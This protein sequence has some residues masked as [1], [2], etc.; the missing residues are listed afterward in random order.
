MS[1]TRLEPPPR[2]ETAVRTVAQALPDAPCPD[3]IIPEPHTISEDAIVRL[4]IGPNGLTRETVVAYAPVTISARF[5]DPDQ[6]REFLRLDF[7]RAGDWHHQIVE[8]SVALDPQKLLGLAVTGFPV[9]GKTAKSLAVYLHAFEGRNCATLRCF[10]M[11]SHAGWE[12]QLAKNGFLLGRTLIGPQGQLGIATTFRELSANRAA[13]KHVACYAV[14]PGDEDLLD[15]FEQAGTLDD[16]KEAV[17]AVQPHPS[18]LLGLYASF[19]PP[20]LSIVKAPNFILDWNV[21]KSVHGIQRSAHL[22]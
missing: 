17:K 10:D 22:G 5:R 2:V 9:A 7:K 20:L 14:T 4:H 15:R 8:R 3:L 13:D 21:P 12:T 11:Y 19:V 18:A 1:Q 6:N 16:W